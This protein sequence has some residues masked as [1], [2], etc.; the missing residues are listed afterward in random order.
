I[1]DRRE[2]WVLETVDRH[3][4]A[5]KV[6]DVRSISNALSIQTHFDLASKD[7]VS[8]A[9]ERGWS[10]KG[11]AFNFAKAYTDPLITFFAGSA[12][13][14]QCTMDSLRRLHGRITP[15]TMMQA[16]RAHRGEHKHGWRPD[17]ALLGT[18]V[19]M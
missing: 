19:C 9:V 18:D 5:E 8:Y 4:A 12:N 17:R 14:H 10:R 3:W 13:R 1:A 16:L 6:Q 2:A 15:Q 11:E 7:L